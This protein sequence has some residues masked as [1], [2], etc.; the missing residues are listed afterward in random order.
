M[1]SFGQRASASPVAHAF[2]E[3]DQEQAQS[4]DDERREREQEKRDREQEARDREQEKADRSSEL[5]DEGR[6]ALDDDK[7]DR[8]E[9][10]FA[11]LAEL[12][13]PQTD[14]ALYWKAYTEN[15]LG[16]RDSALKTIADLKQRFPQSRWQ[17]DAG[18]LQ[19]EVQQSQGQPTHPESQGDDDLKL[20]ALQGLMNSDPD[21]AMPL[22]EKN[23][24]GTGSPK[25]KSRALFLLAQNGSPKAR[26]ILAGIARGQGNPDLQARAVQY[27]GLFGG[28]EAR[29]TLAEIYSASNDPSVKRSILRSYMI[30]GDK[31]RLFAAAKSESNPDLK[32][33]AIRQLGIVHAP[34]ELR[35]LYQ[36]G[37][38]TEVRQELLQAFFL[39]G[40]AAQL[41]QVAETEK[42]P[43]VRRTAI[44]NLGL[45]G[46]DRSGKELQSIY[47]KE[48]DRGVKE[49][50]MNAFFIQGN[51]AALVAVARNEKDPELRKTA[52]SKLSLMHSKE[53][54][55]YLMEILQK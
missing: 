33:E 14:A 52:V 18:A 37:G 3:Q 17:K 44:R 49:E 46:A 7:Y 27:L 4:R 48:S 9:A 47:A 25:E 13:G 11:Q 19:I 41:S 45:I 5:Y 23:L 31:E 38:S 34:E 42:D 32:R 30:A 36:A 40:D 1:L 50:V 26:E 55:D 53:A 54:T 20:L 15:R 6:E 39:A 22:I 24:N 10:K 43:E 51:A 29:K 28:A 16:K 8:A 2:L 35:Q 21:R 12:N